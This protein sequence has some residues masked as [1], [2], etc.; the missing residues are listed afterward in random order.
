MI[1]SMDVNVVLE[2]KHMIPPA[3]AGIFSRHCHVAMFLWAMAFSC[4]LCLERLSRRPEW[5]ISQSRE[6]T[7]LFRP[8]KCATLECQGNDKFKTDLY[9]KTMCF[10]FR[11]ADGFISDG[12][13]SDCFLGSLRW[14]SWGIVQTKINP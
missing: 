8:R 3:R 7:V 2:S 10:L 6:N 13:I 14:K 1:I 11:Y 12:F 5:S 4:A 9:E